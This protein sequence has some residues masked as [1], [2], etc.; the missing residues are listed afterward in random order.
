MDMKVIGYILRYGKNDYQISLAEFKKEDEEA[1]IDIATKY[2]ND[3][4]G[5]RGDENLTIKDANIEYW[6]YGWSKRDREKARIALAE[7]AWDICKKDNSFY[8]DH[9]GKW[10]DKKEMYQSLGSAKSCAYFIE[11]VL[12][13]YDGS[14]E[15]KCYYDLSMDIVHYMEQYMN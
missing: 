14:E 7:K 12:Q 3:S 8:D 2:D 13:F 15:N 1:I 11:T 4:S 6:E 5:I 10:F 9:E